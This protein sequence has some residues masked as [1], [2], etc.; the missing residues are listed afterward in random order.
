MVG[1]KSENQTFIEAKLSKRIYKY[2]YIYIY[3]YR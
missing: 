3:I 2:I 1:L